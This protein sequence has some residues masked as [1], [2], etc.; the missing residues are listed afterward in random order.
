MLGARDEDLIITGGRPSWWAFFCLRDVHAVCHTANPSFHAETQQ[1]IEAKGVSLRGLRSPAK[2]SRNCDTGVIVP[3]HK[4]ESSKAQ[5]SS[6]LASTVWKLGLCGGA[7]LRR[8]HEGLG[9]AEIL[10][11]RVAA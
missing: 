6:V 7:S 9:S 10:E 8:K 4:P 3:T 2:R 1:L 11:S 5:R